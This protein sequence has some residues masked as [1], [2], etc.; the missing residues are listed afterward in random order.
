MRRRSGGFTMPEILTVVIIVAVL[1]AI[2]IPTVAGMRKKASR[3]TCMGDLAKIS[4]ALVLY[5]QENNV[6]PEPD[7]PI[8]TLANASPRLLPQVPTCPRDPEQPH[9]TYGEFYNYWGFKDQVSPT[10]LTKSDAATLYQGLTDSAS[11]KKYYWRGG[12]AGNPDTDFPGLA[13]PNA[14]ADTIVTLCQWHASD[15]GGRYVI[16]LLGG[17]VEFAKPKLNQAKYWTLSEV[18]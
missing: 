2:I 8:G 10:L 4:Q 16:L 15:A 1:A 3:V 11:P 9:D 6:Y 7:N 18:K 12:A 5:R 17:D 13:N 14:T